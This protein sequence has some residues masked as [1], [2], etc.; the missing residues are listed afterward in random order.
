[1]TT[2]KDILNRVHHTRI[3]CRGINQNG[4][5]KCPSNKTCPLILAEGSQVTTKARGMGPQIDRYFQ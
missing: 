3:R 2:Y 5:S 4:K 1:M